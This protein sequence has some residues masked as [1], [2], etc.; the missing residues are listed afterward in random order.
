MDTAKEHIEGR[1]N[2]A[3]AVFMVKYMKTF[4]FEVSNDVFANNS[5]YFRNAL[6]RANYNDFKNE[7][8]ATTEFLEKFFSNMLRII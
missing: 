7:I 4:G 8:Y 6:V 1:I 5:G 2:R 3:T